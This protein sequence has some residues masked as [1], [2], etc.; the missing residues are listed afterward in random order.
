MFATLSSW[1]FLRISKSYV[2]SNGKLSTR[3]KR[4][5]RSRLRSP[6]RAVKVS[7]QH[8]MTGTQAY[9][10]PRQPS[11][12]TCRQRP[13]DAALYQLSMPSVILC[14][15]L[16][17]C[18]MPNSLGERPPKTA[19]KRACPRNSRAACLKCWNQVFSLEKSLQAALHDCEHEH[20]DQHVKQHL[21]KATMAV[22]SAEVI[23]LK[24]SSSSTS[25]VHTFNVKPNSQ[26]RAAPLAEC[27]IGLPHSLRG[28]CACSNQSQSPRQI[29]GLV[30]H[31]A[32]LWQEVL[33]IVVKKRIPFKQIL[34]SVSVTVI[35]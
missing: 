20:R 4:V 33:T 17:L 1:Y 23:R 21:K 32:H 3:E 24:R 14:A 13:P 6:C 11:N 25:S 9:F 22:S 18:S 28:V 34:E 26:P 5:K 16:E 12:S 10:L 31:R 27:V 35:T 8:E 19:P 29:A 15:S 7:G 2:D 30:P